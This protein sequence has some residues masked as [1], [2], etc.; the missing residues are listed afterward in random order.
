MDHSEDVAEEA[1]IE[2]W[3]HWNK[4]DSHAEFVLFT[5]VKNA[6]TL[7]SK[8][9]RRQQAKEPNITEY[10][11][12]IDD[13]FSKKNPAPSMEES[14]VEEETYQYYLD[15]IN[16]Q[17]SSNDQ[18]LFHCVIIKKMSIK[19]TADYLAKSEKAVS[20]VISRLRVK[21]RRQIL[22]EILQKSPTEKK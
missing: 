1:F 18:Q 7:I 19:E 15:E 14:I 17:L 4:L 3:K 12:S 16:K 8:S 5:W 22:P 13:Y 20:V 10:N 11:E 2:L 6:V 21:L 9:Y